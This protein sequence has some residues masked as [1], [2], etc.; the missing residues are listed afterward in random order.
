MT[1]TR[2]NASEVT[3]AQLGAWGFPVEESGKVVGT[4]VIRVEGS[5]RHVAVYEAWTAGHVRMAVTAV[6]AG[7][8]WA[9]AFGKP[10]FQADPAMLAW[11]ASNTRGA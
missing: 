11:A 6:P 9:E 7:M 2:P 5:P 4:K 10:M 8:T 1:D 3:N